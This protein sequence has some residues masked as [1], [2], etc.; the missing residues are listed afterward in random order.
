M[1]VYK[2]KC[3]VVTKSTAEENGKILRCFSNYFYF[4]T[5]LTLDCLLLACNGL[6]LFHANTQYFKKYCRVW[7][8]F[9]VHHI[10]STVKR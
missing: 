4:S 7:Y 2:S 6:R 10:L 9:F 1:I 5:P 3:L 8:I